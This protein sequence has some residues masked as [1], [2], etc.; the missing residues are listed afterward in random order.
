MIKAILKRMRSGDDGTFGT[1]LL[2]DGARE[3]TLYTAELPWRDNA[4]GK[5]CIPPGVYRAEMSP[6]PRFGRELYELAGVPGRTEVLIHNGNW[7]G[8]KSKGKLSQVKGCILVGMAH[9]IVKGQRA[10]T[11]SRTALA[12]LHKFTGGA[13][14]EIEVLG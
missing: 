2:R 3:L 12:A 5:S 8:D 13:P 9:G 11:Q 4:V 14:I 6:S 7:A 10:V 1:L